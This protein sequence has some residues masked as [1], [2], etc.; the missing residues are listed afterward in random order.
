MAAIRRR[1]GRRARRC[2]EAGH[3]RA[4]RVLGHV[5]QH[6]QEPGDPPLLIG[7]ALIA[8]LLLLVYRPSRRW[9][10][11]CC[12]S[13]V[14]RWSASPRSAWALARCTASP[15]GFG[16]ALIGEAVGLFHLP[17]RAI[18]AARR[19]P[20]GLDRAVLADGAARSADLHRRLCLAAA[21]RV[22][23]LA[24]LGL[25]SI[26]GLIA[27]ASVTRFV[28]PHLLP[29]AFPDF[30]RRIGARRQLVPLGGARRRVALGRGPGV[31]G[32]LCRPRPTPL[33]HMEPEHLCAEPGVASRCGA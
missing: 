11:V 1:C 7:T 21:V 3:D 22:S 32:G 6:H 8:A 33:E 14:V 18:G 28:L 31:A 19:R 27:A 5:T 20:A 13:S 30:R 2:R 12:R 4:R 24:Q 9:H 29:L 17:V 23:R 10:W 25:Y 15:L 26:A 16:T